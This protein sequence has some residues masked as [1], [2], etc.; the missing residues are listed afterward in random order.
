MIVDHISNDRNLEYKLKTARKIRE[1]ENSSQT[2]VRDQAMAILSMLI[3]LRSAFNVR[4]YALFRSRS[5]NN[6]SRLYEYNTMLL[7]YTEDNYT[8][9]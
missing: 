7:I 8:R 6:C 3:S 1:F 9:S 5:L 2:R 4:Q